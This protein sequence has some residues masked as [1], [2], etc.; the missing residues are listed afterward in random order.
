VR[1]EDLEVF[2]LAC[3]H[4]AYFL[5]TDEVTVVEYWSDNDPLSGRKCI[6]RKAVLCSL[7]DMV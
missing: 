4:S 1:S 2:A 7:S 3:C 5:L 6:M